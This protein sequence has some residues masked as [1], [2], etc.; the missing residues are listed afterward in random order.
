MPLIIAYVKAKLPFVIA[1]PIH[2]KRLAVAIG[3]RAKTDKLD[4][5]LIVHYGNAIK[6]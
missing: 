3:R 5:Q 6:P 4:A 2:I 1:N